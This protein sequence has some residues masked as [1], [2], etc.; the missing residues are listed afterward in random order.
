MIASKDQ[1]KKRVAEFPGAHCGLMEASVMAPLFPNSIS[2][3][4]APPSCSFHAKLVA[5]RR[6]LSTSRKDDRLFCLNLSQEDLI[7]GVEPLL[8]ET[9]Q[10]LD[11]LFQPELIFVISTCTPEIIGFDASALTLLREQL[12]AKV[13]VVPTNGY[14][15]L[16]QQKGSIDFLCSLVEVMKRKETIPQSVNIL[17]LRSM[18][19]EEVEYI[20][21]LEEAGITINALLPGAEHLSEIENVPNAALN[22]VVSKIALPLAKKMEETFRIP[23]LWADFSYKTE[24]IV[25]GYEKI[26]QFFDL[27][28]PDVVE[29]LR[30]EHKQFIEEKRKSLQG[31]SFAIG[32]VKGSNIEAAAFYAELG[33]VPKFITT[34][35][36]ASGND[37]NLQEIRDRGFDCPV[38]QLE[39]GMKMKDFLQR[40]RPQIFI[41]HAQSELLKQENVL[42]CHPIMHRSGPGFA[43]IQQELENMTDLI[44]CGKDMKII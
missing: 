44:Q 33:M 40:Y 28:L 43:A 8:E 35:M 21:V 36:P 27:P 30:E 38:I 41:G 32:S 18:D 24:Q 26:V 12:H 10:E 23:Y 19:L 22:I 25:K 42:H 17:G 2:I 11:D 7:F 31:V 29:R 15:S 13:V 37:L 14:E 1:T 34:R 3:V 4:V 16:H 39:R 9:L 20:R 6:L 5:S